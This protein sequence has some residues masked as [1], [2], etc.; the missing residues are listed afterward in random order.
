MSGVNKVIIV[1]RLG[2]DP[3]SK[4]LDGGQT[5]A[6]M[7]LATSEKWTDKDGNKQEK[8]EWTRVTCWGKTAE[9]C[10]KYLK[11]GSQAYVEGKLQTRSWEDEQGNKKYMTEVVAQTVQFLDSKGSAEKTESSGNEEIPF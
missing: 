8:T 11:K 1:G 9:N 10:A 5:V 6:N 3:E 7:S 2:A 4:T